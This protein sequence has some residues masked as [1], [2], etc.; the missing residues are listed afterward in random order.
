MSVKVFEI[1][2]L[3]GSFK[4]LFSTKTSFSPDLR[5]PEEIRYSS[6]SNPPDTLSIMRKEVNVTLCEVNQ[7]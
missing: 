7:C 1:S 4:S 3:V 2:W 5:F 6:E